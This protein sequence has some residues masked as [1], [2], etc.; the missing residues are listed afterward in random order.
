MESDE[1]VDE[2]HTFLHAKEKREKKTMKVIKD[3]KQFSVREENIMKKSHFN[4]EERAILKV[5]YE[6]RRSMNI[7][8]IARE[9][10]VSWATVKKYLPELVKKG[11][12]EEDE[13]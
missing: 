9:A 2:L 13:T 4:K 3:K 8:E 5:I 6:A 7:S 11:A 10:K 12:I 1:I